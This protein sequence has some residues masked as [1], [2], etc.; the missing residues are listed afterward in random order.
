MIGK[1]ISIY[2][3]EVIK[4]DEL[5]KITDRNELT[6]YLKNKTYSLGKV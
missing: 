1:E 3:G 4:F 5:N 6:E 2:S